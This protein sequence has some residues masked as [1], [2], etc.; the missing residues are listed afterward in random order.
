MKERAPLQIKN[1]ARSSF[2]NASNK[3]KVEKKI[4]LNEDM[5]GIFDSAFAYT[6]RYMSPDNK[7]DHADNNRSTLKAIVADNQSANHRS[8][9]KL[10]GKKSSQYSIAVEPVFDAKL[11]NLDY[12]IRSRSKSKMIK[13]RSTL[14]INHKQK[15][16]I[17]NA[18]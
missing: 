13:N 1:N 18:K 11:Q 3:K 8:N 12:Q 15:Q 9:S 6:D 10:K 4:E 2:K 16:K 14:A 7:S 17:K 5:K